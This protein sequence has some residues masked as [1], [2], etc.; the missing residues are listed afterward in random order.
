MKRQTTDRENVYKKKVLQGTV[1][2]LYIRNS[3]NTV[4]QVQISS[5]HNGQFS[6]FPKKYTWIANEH[7]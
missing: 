3:D 6:H 7:T 2:R 5:L 1:S 4:I